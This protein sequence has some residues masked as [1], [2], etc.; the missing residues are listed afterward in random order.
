MSTE[1]DLVAEKEAELNELREERDMLQ[2]QLEKSPRLVMP[3][4]G[5]VGEKHSSVRGHFI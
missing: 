3:P 5:V 1:I 2:A 4:C